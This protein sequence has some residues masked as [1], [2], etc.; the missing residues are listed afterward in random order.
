MFALLRSLV[1]PISVKWTVANTLSLVFI[2]ALPKKNVSTCFRI[3]FSLPDLRFL[4]A[5]WHSRSPTRWCRTDNSIKSLCFG[6]SNRLI[7]YLSVVLRQINF[8]RLFCGGLNWTPN[9]AT[10]N[11]RCTKTGTSFTFMHFCLR[12]FFRVF[13][14]SSG[15]HRKISNLTTFHASTRRWRIFQ[16][17]ET[18]KKKSSA[19]WTNKLWNCNQ[20]LLIFIGRS[21]KFFGVHSNLFKISEWPAI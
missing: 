3:F 13:H 5:Q 6:S 15:F 20:F 14:F 2:D 7:I 12:I 9:Y 4:I 16:E 18:M 10:I 21:D 17:L 1:L 11:Y 19:M 8:S